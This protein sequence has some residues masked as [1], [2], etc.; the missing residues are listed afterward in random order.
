MA[1]CRSKKQRPVLCQSPV[2][3][4]P[5]AGFVLLA[6]LAD[7]CPYP[8]LPALGIAW[9]PE[10]WGIQFG[11]NTFAN[12]LESGCLKVCSAFNASQPKFIGFDSLFANRPP[13]R[14]D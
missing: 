1:N 14:L 7:A 6:V 13:S 8:N 2:V 11:C 5:A 4:V 12:S 3:G 10:I 9:F